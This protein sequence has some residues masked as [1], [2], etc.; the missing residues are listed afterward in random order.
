MK[1]LTPLQLK[2][3]ITTTPEVKS[4]QE[5]KKKQEITLG[6]CLHCDLKFN[7]VWLSNNKHYC[8]HYQ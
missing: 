8:E 2:T 1:V 3:E 7:C 6:L 4:K 5:T